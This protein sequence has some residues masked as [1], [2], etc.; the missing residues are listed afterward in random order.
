MSTTKYE[1]A[2]GATRKITAAQRLAEIMC[3]RIAGK[4]QRSLPARFWNTPQWN[5][6]FYD[7]IRFAN[8]ILKIYDA[9]VIFRALRRMPHVWSLGAAFFVESLKAEERS[10]HAELQRAEVAAPPPTSTIS[11]AP[12]V[13]VSR[14]RSVRAKLSK[15][16]AQK[17]GD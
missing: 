5:K 10:Y 13:G 7:Q 9:E 2:H 4:D 12:S 8:S 16:D 6:T 3:E 15:I 11:Q 14:V 17:K 1:S